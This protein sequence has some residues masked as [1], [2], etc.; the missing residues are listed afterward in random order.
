MILYLAFNFQVLHKNMKKQFRLS[1]CEL[2]DLNMNRLRKKLFC[3]FHFTIFNMFFYKR[4]FSILNIVQ[5][6]NN[7]FDT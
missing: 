3:G 4:N 7:V 6:A 5:L 1:L 2:H